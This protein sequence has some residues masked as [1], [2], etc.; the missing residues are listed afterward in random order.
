MNRHHYSISAFFP[1]YKDEGTVDLMVNRLRKVLKELTDD[2][3]IIIV[4]DC[5]PDKSGQI[6]DE[7]AK[8]YKEIRVIHHKKNLGYGGALRSGFRASAKDLVF[9]TDGDAQYDVNELK[10]LM[11]Y[12]DDYDFITAIKIKRADK[13]YRILLSN[14]Y[15]DTLR[16]L[17]GIRVKDISG[18]FRLFRR[19]VVDSLDLISNSGTVCIEIVKKVQNRKFRTKEV[20]V[21]HYP[22]IS[23]ESAYFNPIQL[24][25]TFME[26]APLWW[27]L[28]VKDKFVAKN[29]LRKQIQR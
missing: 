13:L 17:F 19:N 15:Y 28:V 10:E 20:Y 9:Y 16:L 1:V 29:E 27:E 3:E 7:L 25:K 8:H 14:F 11:K 4:D 18:D 23:G 21:H 12:A 24:I 5:S 6:A 22:R 2:Y 26:L